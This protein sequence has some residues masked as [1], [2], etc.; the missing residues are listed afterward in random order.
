MTPNNLN[1]L[2]VVAAT[3]TMPETGVWYA[4]VSL[5]LEPG[6]VAPT[7]R[8]ALMLGD[9]LC[10]G[11]VDD[12]FSGT[13]GENTAVRVRGGGGGWGKVVSAQHYHNDGGVPL[14]SVAVT[15]GVAAGEVV[16]VLEDTV[17]GADF[18]RAKERA[19]RVLDGVSWWVGLDGITRIGKRVEAPLSPALGAEV[20]EYD[21]AAQVVTLSADG[22]VEPG[23]VLTDERFDRLVV[24]DVEVQVDG[25]GMRVR[26]SVGPAAGA[27][28][29]SALRRVAL[30]ASGA[31]WCRSYRYRVVVD[32]GDRLVLSAVREKPGLPA[33][34][35][36]SI[37]H[38]VPGVSAML[39]PGAEVLV[40]FIE[41][42][43]AQPVVVAFEP[44]EGAGFKPLMLT[45][46]AQTFVSVGFGPTALPVAHAIQTMANDAALLAA[47]NAI[48]AAFTSLGP[49]PLLGAIAGGVITGAGA[50]AAGV[51]SASAALLPTTKLVAE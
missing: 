41:G 50:T 43:P 48:G 32:G 27:R 37:W 21:P 29:L 44:S 22:L 15:T 35:P 20:L 23:A 2:R 19:S 3:L 17:L 4:D 47:I 30:E 25:D 5:D 14:S 39:L 1:G 13:F 16:T 7:G 26:A 40:E 11:T 18:V 31:V 24:R 45:L 46:D 36:V 49:I 8:V 12:A 28:L 34:L 42:D 33:L 38:G 6:Q 10:V 9:S 51:L